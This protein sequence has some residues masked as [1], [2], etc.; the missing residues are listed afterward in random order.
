MDL[1]PFKWCFGRVMGIST[2]FHLRSI[3]G[4]LFHNEATCLEEVTSPLSGIKINC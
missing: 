1:T 4:A 2:A 3:N